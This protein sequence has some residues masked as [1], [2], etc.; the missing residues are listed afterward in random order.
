MYYAGYNLSWKIY[1]K[2]D[3]GESWIVL[4]A[5][6]TIPPLIIGRITALLKCQR[7]IDLIRYN[8]IEHGNVQWESHISE[9]MWG[10]KSLPLSRFIVRRCK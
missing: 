5:E 8:I 2:P 10:G 6:N 9:D 4:N 1:R 7:I 3:N